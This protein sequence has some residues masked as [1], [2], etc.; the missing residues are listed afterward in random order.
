MHVNACKTAGE[1]TLGR[2]KSCRKSENPEI[3]RLSE[4]QKKLRDDIN[5][6]KDKNK[7]QEKKRE[8]NNILKEIK[9][10]LRIE[11]TVQ[12][13]K[14]IEDLEKHKN[15]ST[16]MFKA[17]KAL[18]ISEPKKEIIVD[19]ENG[20]VTDEN[21]QCAIITDFFRNMFFKENEDPFPDIKPQEMKNTV[22]T[23][24]SG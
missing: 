12:I 6:C 22:Y 24:R 8:R 5:A 3:K 7:R 9:E 15:D 23:R 17:I 4:M 13:E 2:K 11:E 19:S 16:K 1:Q 14:K 20:M 21:T 18:K 10:K